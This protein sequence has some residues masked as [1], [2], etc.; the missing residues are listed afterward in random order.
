MKKVL[1]V[2]VLGIVGVAGVVI[3]IGIFESDVGGPIETCEDL[4][5][6]IIEMS[7]EKR[8][9]FSTKILKMYDINQN[10]SPDKNR[11][12][13]CTATAKMDRVAMLASPSTWK[14]MPMETASSECRGTS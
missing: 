14:K 4:A 5:S 12:L 1:K 13:E 6:S 10:A 11:P 9:L 3:V 7:E 8:G 2:L